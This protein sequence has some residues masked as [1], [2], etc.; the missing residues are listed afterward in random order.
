[1]ENDLLP[2]QNLIYE[3]REDKVML[4]S[5]LAMLYGVETKY[6]NRQ[7]KRNINRFPSDFMFQLNQ[8]EWEV[9]RCHIGT[10]NNKSR[11]GRQYLPY[12]FTEHGILMLSSIL[13]SKRASEINIQIM[14]IF[15]QMRKYTINQTS[16]SQEIQQLRQM[17]ILHI[18]N[19]DNRINE[20]SHTINKIIQAL[21]NLIDNP[22]KTKS[23]QIG[24][25]T[26]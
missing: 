13:N 11:G 20:H 15:V 7:V 23:S 4:D 2:I 25:K 14:R 18:E 9:L 17:L 6:L 8:K 21:N 19:T 3:I 26:Q 1:M 24:F 5:D 10:S 22:H 16:Q 12:V